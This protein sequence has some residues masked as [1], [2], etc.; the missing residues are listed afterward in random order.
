MGRLWPEPPMRVAGHLD[1]LCLEAHHELLYP[2]SCVKSLASRA[3]RFALISFAHSFPS[4]PTESLFS[5]LE[6]VVTTHDG[7]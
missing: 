3:I 2:S 1:E 6:L 7:A 5:K 4:S